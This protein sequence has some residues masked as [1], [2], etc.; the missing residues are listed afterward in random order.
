MSM[1]FVNIPALNGREKNGWKREG[2][3]KELLGHGHGEGGWREDEWVVVDTFVCERK[4]DVKID[5]LKR[6]ASDIVRR[7]GRMKVLIVL[8]D[9]KNKNQ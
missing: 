2:W 6:L 3:K 4:E 7:V 9:V 8:D 1:S 5:P